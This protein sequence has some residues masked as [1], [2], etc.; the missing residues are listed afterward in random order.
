MRTTALLIVTG[1]L[2]VGCKNPGADVAP[3]KVEPA[4]DTK[5]EAA[6]SGKPDEAT[7]GS[8][9]INPSNSKIEFVG[10]KVTAS[11]DGGFTD[12]SGKVALGDPVEA[13]TIELTIQ[14][15]SLFADKEKLTKHLKSPDFFDV[16]KFP[17]ATFRSTEITKDGDGHTISGDLTLH[18]VTKRISFP[19]AVEV[20]ET[21]VNASAEFSINRQDF[22]I[23]Y[24]GM[25]DDLIRDLVVI[26]LSLK[27]PRQS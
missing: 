9:A 24:A 19:A 12:F 5:A 4:P 10:A 15:E 13:S 23:A 21:E 3:A 27:L 6:P 20:T 17:T 11:H 8:L 1:L 16:A 26:K 2:V 14:T 22:G 18:G 25:K 7:A